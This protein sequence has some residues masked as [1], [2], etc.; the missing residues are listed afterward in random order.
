VIV[1]KRTA[2]PG[3]NRRAL[4]LTA[5]IIAKSSRERPADAA[6]REELRNQRDLDRKTAAIVT[7]AVFAFYRWFG[8]L[9]HR[10]ILIARIEQAL[11]LVEAFAKYPEQ[12]SE[13]DLLER[14]VPAWTKGEMKMSAEWVRSLQSEPIFWL[15]ARAGEASEVKRQL[16]HCRVF[17]PEKWA[18]TLQYMG[19]EDLFRTSGFHSGQF[20]IQ[21]VASQAVGFIC[22]PHAGE[23]WWDSCAGEGG[24]TLHLSGL[25]RNKGL[26]WTSDRAAWRLQRLKRRAARAGVFNYRSAIWDGGAKLPTKTK[27]DG[28]LLD[29]PCSGVGNWQRNPHARWTTTPADLVDLSNLQTQLLSNACRAVKPGGKLFYVVCTLTRVETA[30]VVES[31]EKQHP[32]FEP[33]EIINPFNDQKNR[34]VWIWPQDYKCNGMFAAGW[35]RK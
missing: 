23:L 33:M 18:D 12:F 21:D 32:E 3:L 22:N 7:N 2:P 4:D 19:R 24:K 26:I 16:D 35:I 25:M 8:W 30:A 29:A 9:D 17:G 1:Y 31:F 15:R 34:D 28:V 20:E 13:K 27:F 11:G 5:A 14:A 6:L 10:A